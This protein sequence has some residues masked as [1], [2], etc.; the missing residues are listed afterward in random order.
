MSTLVSIVIPV[1]NAAKYINRCL[2]TIIN[3]TYNNIEIIIIND[4]STDNSLELIS[5]YTSMHSIIKVI[6]KE[7][8]G[9]GLARKLAVEISRGKYIFFV[10]ADDYIAINTVEKLVEVAEKNNADIAVCNI[11]NEE[12]QN[13]D[14]LSNIKDEVISLKDRKA[15]F[16]NYI[17]NN[18]LYYCVIGKMFNLSRIREKRI[19][20]SENLNFGEDLL[21][22]LQLYTFINSIAIVHEKLYFYSFDPES[23]TR[24]FK[25]DRCY[26]QFLILCKY[27]EFLMERNEYDQY[28]YIMSIFLC[29]F[30]MSALNLSQ[31]EG[32]EKR[33]L[34]LFL[35]YVQNSEIY[36]E[37]VKNKN[38]NNS[39]IKWCII[40]NY[41]IKSLIKYYLISICMKYKWNPLL[42]SLFSIRRKV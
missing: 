36:F 29:M 30:S 28:M 22:L 38:L 1:Y 26:D 4:G 19:N 40:E 15:F 14:L 9:V 41:S 35:E 39:M 34:I 8:G 27:R 42:L 18:K 25:I 3:Q 17:I 20:F 21:F 13:I 10:D 33:D 16:E 24:T 12:N 6:N 23:I 37:L 31:K 5:E 2:D 7:N 32:A 11:W